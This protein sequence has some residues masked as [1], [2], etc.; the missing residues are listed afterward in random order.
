MGGYDCG[1]DPSELHEPWSHPSD[2]SHAAASSW[3]LCEPWSQPSDESHAAASSWHCASLGCSQARNRT[4]LH[5][6]GIVPAVL[7]GI[8]RPTGKQL[9]DLGPFVTQTLLRVVQNTRLLFG[10]RSLDESRV[11]CIY[12]AFANALGD[13]TRGL[14]AMMGQDLPSSRVFNRISSSW[15]SHGARLI[16]GFHACRKKADEE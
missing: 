10:P 2:E 16:P 15:S 13:K 1:P 8:L 6:L 14:V 5:H 4:P 12:E 7:D 9:S 3:H 11:Q